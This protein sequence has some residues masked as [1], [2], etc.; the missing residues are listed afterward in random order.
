LRHLCGF[1]AGNIFI[2]AMNKPSLPQPSGLRGAGGQYLASV[3]PHRLSFVTSS[4]L[5]FAVRKGDSF[6]AAGTS[7]QVR[8]GM[9]R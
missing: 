5:S 9:A 4:S 8:L 1:I 6:L 3:M 2:A 7:A